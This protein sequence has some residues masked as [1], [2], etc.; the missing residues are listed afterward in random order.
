MLPHWKHF[1]L[2]QRCE[3]ANGLSHGE[4]LRSIAERIGMDPTSV[5]K[6]IK[7]NRTKEDAKGLDAECKRTKR[8]PYVCDCCPHKY[9]R[10]K[11]G[12]LRIRY[13]ARVAQAMADRRLRESREGYD[14][15]QEAFKEVDAALTAG[16]AEKKSVYEISRLPQVAKVASPQTLYRWVSAGF[17]EA[18]RHDLPK[19]VKYKKRK[20]KQYDYGGASKGKDGRNYADYLAHRRENPGEY[21]CQMD[22]L[23]SIK[24]DSKALLVVVIPELQFPYIRLMKKASPKAVRN[25]WD[26]IDAKIGGK[27]FRRI[28]SFILTDNDPCFS[29]FASIERGDDGEVRT[30]VFYADAYVSNQKANVENMNGQLRLHFP[31]GSSVDKL[32]ADRVKE[33]NLAMIERPLKSL[34]GLTPRAAFEAVYG[35]GIIELL[36]DYDDVD[37][38][39]E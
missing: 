12:R 4:S 16:L 7:R 3:I 18:K 9:D 27:A 39:G 37:M 22:F 24:S 25:F 28:F 20:R 15:T 13:N 36:L 17:T 31:K 14:C 10:E 2:A 34:A 5:S 38:D 33:A 11:C 19:A 29:D 21:G 35:T 6:E 1:D 23:G 26:W 30:R 8:F 32:T